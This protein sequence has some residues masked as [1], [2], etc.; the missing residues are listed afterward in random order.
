MMAMESKSFSKDQNQRVRKKKKKKK[1][2]KKNSINLII[3]SFVSPSFSYFVFYFYYHIMMNRFYLPIR[4]TLVGGERAVGSIGYFI[5]KGY[6]D[7]LPLYSLPD[8]PYPYVHECQRFAE[9][10][11]SRRYGHYIWNWTRW[12]QS[13]IQRYYVIG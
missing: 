12:K 4:K 7:H 6:H 8:Y 10:F 1:K 5:G 11:G 9:R 2:K 13:Q 3:P